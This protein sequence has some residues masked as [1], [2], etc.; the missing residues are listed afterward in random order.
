MEMLNDYL[1][2]STL[3]AARVLK[4]R[5]KFDIVGNST[6]GDDDTKELAKKL[7]SLV[8]TFRIPLIFKD[9]VRKRLWEEIRSDTVLTELILEM[10]CDYVRRCYACNVDYNGV[11]AT[12]AKAYGFKTNDYTVKDEELEKVLSTEQSILNTLTANPWLVFIVELEVLMVR[13]S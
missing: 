10:S 7:S 8:L 5:A 9:S 11:I 2:E 13:F 4:D 6:S 1:S 12:I 3:I